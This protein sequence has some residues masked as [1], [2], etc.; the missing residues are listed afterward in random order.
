M[1]S[2]GYLANNRV[3][4]SLSGEMEFGNLKITLAVAAYKELERISSNLSYGHIISGLFLSRI[5]YFQT[6]FNPYGTFNSYYRGVYENVNIQD[7]IFSESG[8]ELSSLFDSDGNMNFDKYYFASDLHLKFNGKIMNKD[9]YVFS[10]TNYN[11]AQDYLTLL[12]IINDEAFLRQFCTQID[13]VY[14]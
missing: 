9:F 10:L 6:G 11:T 1:N 8:Y 12:P 5:S 14:N 7:T 13:L 3:G 2:V 4:G